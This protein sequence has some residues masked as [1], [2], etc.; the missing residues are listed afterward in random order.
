MA[1]NYRP[2]AWYWC[3]EHG[4]QKY[5]QRTRSIHCDGWQCLHYSMHQK[6]LVL[7]HF[8]Y[9]FF[10][11]VHRRWGT[12]REGSIVE[13]QLSGQ[14]LLCWSDLSYFPEGLQY[15]CLRRLAPHGGSLN[16]QTLHLVPVSHRCAYAWRHYRFVLSTL[17][18]ILYSAL[19]WQ[20][21]CQSFNAIILN[22]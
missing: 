8:S 6:S 4:N 11:K 3:M 18:P 9:C 2:Y 14:S 16:H 12:L 20:A 5:K 21:Y 17:W 19:R 1:C 13:G 22:P 7:R 15:V 10:S